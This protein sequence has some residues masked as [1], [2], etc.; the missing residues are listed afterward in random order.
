MNFSPLFNGEIA[1]IREMV[2]GFLVGPHGIESDHSMEVREHCYRRSCSNDQGLAEST[3][4]FAEFNKR[5][6][7]ELV[8]QS[9][10]IRCRLDVRLDYEKREHGATL[11]GRDQRGM[12]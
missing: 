10:K 2:S 8:V 3:Q 1:L 7:N 4:V 9:V 6:A 11:C 12:I 5:P